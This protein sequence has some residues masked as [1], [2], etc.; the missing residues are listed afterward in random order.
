MDGNPD[1]QM[2]HKFNQ[3]CDVASVE[4]CEGGALVGDHLYV[5]DSCHEFSTNTL[6][7]GEMPCSG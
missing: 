3:S 6:I 5:A 1:S 7:G 2:Q 4:S